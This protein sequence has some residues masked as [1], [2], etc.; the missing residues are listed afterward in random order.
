MGHF[1]S[2]ESHGASGGHPDVFHTPPTSP[3]NEGP[4]LDPLQV[5]C[6]SSPLSPLVAQVTCPP[7]VPAKT[8]LPL[9]TGKKSQLGNAPTT[10]IP[11]PDWKPPI[12][13]SAPTSVVIGGPGESLLASPKVQGAPPG[14]NGGPSNSTPAPRAQGTQRWGGTASPNDSPVALDSPASHDTS[15][16]DRHWREMDSGLSQS[17]SREVPGEAM[18]TMLEQCRTTLGLTDGA[19]ST[20]ELLKCL[21]TEIN[22]LRTNLQTE[23]MEWLQFQTDLQVAVAV[24]D[25]LRAEA[26]EDLLALRGAHKEVKRELASAHQRQRE[27]DTQLESLRGE[28]SES[29]KELAATAAAQAHGKTQ[30]QASTEA[31]DK[32]DSCTNNRGGLV[33]TDRGRTRSL[34]G[35][36]REG[37]AIGSPNGT[38]MPNAVTKGEETKTETRGVA[39][40]YMRNVTGEGGSKETSRTNETRRTGTTERSRSL[41]RIALSLDSHTPHNGTSQSNS[42]TTASCTNKNSNQLRVQRSLDWPESSSANAGKREELLN[43][44]NSA[45]S[46]LPPT[47]SQD[48]FNMLL[49]RHGGSKRN[50]LLRWCQ[51]RT[52][53]YKNIDLTNF[54]S[55]WVDGLAFCAV[56]HTYLPSHVPYPSLNPENKR[57]NL[58]LAFKTGENVGITRSLTADE[59]LRA[60]GPDWQ[61]VLS[62]VE[63]MYRHFEM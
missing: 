35:L 37:T 34:H 26:E 63:S 42:G 9:C 14:C 38:A 45:L 60:G 50:S 46:E 27:A 39:R 57:E 2:K 21:L 55:S 17:P 32:P 23:R 28:L 49:R 18:E 6:T 51:N 12:P 15:R 13:P 36:G 20:T 54:S 5:K 3:T 8:P 56:Y 24:A 41:S 11:P 33:G 59:M 4:A 44:Y 53:G 48:G 22:S 31:R 47:K 16:A 10:P 19:P 29:R 43:K 40:R 58:N 62:Y 61:R 25:R 7:P 52:L 30:A 1:S